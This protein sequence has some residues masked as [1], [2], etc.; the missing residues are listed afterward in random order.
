VTSAGELKPKKCIHAVGPMWHGGVEGEDTTLR[1]CVWKSLQQTDEL[2]LASI[3]IPAISSGIFGFPK[4]R[5]AQVLFDTVIDF[6]KENEK[7][8]LKEV[9]F[10]N[11][12]SKTVQIFADEFK[13]RFH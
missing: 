13:K 12:D 4:E 8:T 10:T 11:F 6:Y 5:C 3:S 1:T 2:G 7:S 9:R